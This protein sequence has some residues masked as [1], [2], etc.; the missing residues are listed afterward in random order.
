MASAKWL[1]SQPHN[2]PVEEKISGTLA[3]T[4]SAAASEL[5]LNY[6]SSSSESDE[7][8]VTEQVKKVEAVT[9]AI[10]SSSSEEENSEEDKR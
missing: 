1:S 10:D 2:G 9:K 3:N 8:P 4:S 6:A 5:G 7:D